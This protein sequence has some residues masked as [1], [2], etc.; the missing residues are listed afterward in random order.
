[1]HTFPRRSVAALPGER[2]LDVEA[3]RVDG[4]RPVRTGGEF[5]DHLADQ[6]T[7][8]PIKRSRLV[9]V[10]ARVPDREMAAA[11]P[12]Q[13]AQQYIEMTNGQRRET[14]EAATRWLQQHLGSLRA[15]TEEASGTI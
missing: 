2:V 13:V 1:M 10:T 11:I 9:R 15:R 14:S 6:I 4:E 8:E 12:N 7:I 5:L 3:V